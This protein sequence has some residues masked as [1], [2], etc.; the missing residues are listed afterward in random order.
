MTP[1]TP[2]QVGK[3]HAGQP[4]NV[5]EFPGVA[6]GFLRTGLRLES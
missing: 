6:A 1:Y 4:E 5:L 2:V 3:K